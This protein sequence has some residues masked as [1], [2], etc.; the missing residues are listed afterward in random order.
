VSFSR[1]PDAFG[2]LLLEPLQLPLADSHPGAYFQVA[3]RKS[4]LLDLP[5]LLRAPNVLKLSGERSG[6][7]PALLLDGAFRPLPQAGAHCGW[8]AG[9]DLPR[10]QH[11]LSTVMSLVGNE[12]S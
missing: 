9:A 12:V 3:H 7:E 10:R 6:A 2:R 1:L 5:L 8:Q 11:D 4:P